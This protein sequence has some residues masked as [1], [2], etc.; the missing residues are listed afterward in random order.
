MATINQTLAFT[1]TSRV[2]SVFSN[3]VMAFLVS[4]FLLPEEIGYYYSFASL[5]GAQVL[6]EL[7]I[8]YLA[9]QF[10]S[11][12][13]AFLEW[14]DGQNLIGEIEQQHC[15]RSLYLIVFQW[16]KY[17]S[18]FFAIVVSCFGLWFF[19]RSKTYVLVKWELPWVLLVCSSGVAMLF[20]SILA[21]VEGCRGVEAVARLKLY[22]GLVSSIVSWMT[23]LLGGGLLALPAA[24]LAGTMTGIIVLRR[25][26]GA[27]IRS[28]LVKDSKSPLYMSWKKDIWPLQSRLAISWISGYFIFQTFVP[29]VF[30]TSGPTEAGRFGF[31]LS[32]ANT[33]LATCVSW[34]NTAS[35][36]FGEMIVKSE[37]VM[38]FKKSKRV[39]YSSVVFFLVASCVA[40]VV[41][42]VIE[43]YRFNTG[44]QLISACQFLILL[45]A[46]LLNYIVICHAT[47]LRAF[48]KEP[49]LL[50][51]VIVAVITLLS[52]EFT[53]RRYGLNGVLG[54]YLLASVCSFLISLKMFLKKEAIL[55]LPTIGGGAL[56]V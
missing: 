21:L 38:L 22:Q 43:I 47:V 8:G 13:F 55:T 15:L 6:F 12:C 33:L 54:S 45:L 27:F 3:F 16:S 41:V 35:P 9:T 2:W 25:M 20:Q 32:L 7:G 49:Y 1:L 4:R 30:K 14:K 42:R 31:S 28:M 10:A 52:L 11:H 17:A 29:I 40:V 51:S 19:A 53:A 46:T 36:S 39:M 24:S 50:V 5:I 18:F 26:K 44:F 23:L 34:F 37:Y 48:K 56:L